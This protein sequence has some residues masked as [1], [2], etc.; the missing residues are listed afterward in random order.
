MT[1]IFN[2]I[3]Q[4]TGKNFANIMSNYIYLLNVNRSESK[5]MRLAK[6]PVIGLDSFVHNMI[7]N[8]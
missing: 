5:L 7:I 6:P 8:L 2:I 3:W 1:V 4:E